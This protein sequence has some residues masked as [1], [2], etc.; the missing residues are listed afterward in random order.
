MPLLKSED[1]SF[2]QDTPRVSPHYKCT[3]SYFAHTLISI[4]IEI[5]VAGVSF[6]IYDLWVDFSTGVYE[7][8]KSIMKFR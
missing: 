7:K 6:L 5:L 1:I 8:K 4:G 2:T 3:S